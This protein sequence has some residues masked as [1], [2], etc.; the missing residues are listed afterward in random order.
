MRWRLIL[1]VSLGLNFVLGS[2]ALHWFRL[3]AREIRKSPVVS[4]LPTPA[5]SPVRTN[6]VVRRLS[7]SWNEVE[8]D[9]YP[10][11]I[12]HLREIGC[13]DA[14]IRDII[15]ADVNQL[16]AKRQ[17]AE[18]VEPDQQWWRA[19]PDPE[20]EQAAAEKLHSLDNERRELLTRLLGPGW[21]PT[22]EPQLGSPALTGPVLG[23]LPKETKRAVQE[24]NERATKRLQE[25]LDEQGKRGGQ[26]DQRE[27]AKLRQQTREEL[28]RLLSPE[29]LEEYLLRHSQTAVDL[30]E[31]LRG[32]DVT[33]EEFRAL[34]RLR[35]PFEQQIQLA[36]Q[37]NDSMSAIQRRQLEQQQEAALKNALGAERYQ[38]FTLN[39]DPLYHEAK[40]A[41][42]QLDAPADAVMSIYKLNQA[43]EAQRQRI[44]ND[45]SLSMRERTAA[46]K[47]IQDEQNKSILRLLGREVI[48]TGEEDDD[49]Q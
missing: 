44:Q 11:Y 15:V 19:E 33:P 43:T 47:L 3:P 27:M 13:P 4:S 5:A 28:G 40:N 6:V 35:D 23:T 32:T 8:S 31:Q 14:T 24:I 38:A 26:V 49:G 46:L 42:E 17:A 48:Q 30:R 7:F 25:F 45:G 29:Q 10:T 12:A 37:P 36:G 16:Y 1:L 22:E 41:A 34:F 39:R 21:D 9:D 18:V 20:I 2:M